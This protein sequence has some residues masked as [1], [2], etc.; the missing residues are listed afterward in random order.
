MVSTGAFMTTGTG[1]NPVPVLKYTFHVDGLDGEDAPAPTCTRSGRPSPFTS[2][3]SCNVRVSP[4]PYASTRIGVI[5]AVP[6]ARYDG[7]AY[8]CTAPPKPR[9]VPGYTVHGVWRASTKSGS[10][11]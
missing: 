11:S 10:P 7:G 4:P 2:R 1:A 6:L 8:H 5:T 9:P 3:T